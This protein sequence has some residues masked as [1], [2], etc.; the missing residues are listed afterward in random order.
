MGGGQEQVSRLRSQITELTC[1]IRVIESHLSDKNKTN[2]DTGKRMSPR[3][4]HAWRKNALRAMA[5]KLEQKRAFEAQLREVLGE[6]YS[7]ILHVDLG[8]CESLLKACY[9]A[10]ERLKRD[11]GPKLIPQEVMMVFDLVRDRALGL[12]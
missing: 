4:Y 10:H 12:A 7:G 1:E 2:K 11:V 8:D 6:V 3:Q 5:M 9:A